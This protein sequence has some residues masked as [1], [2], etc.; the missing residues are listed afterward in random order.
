[1]AVGDS[2]AEI[3]PCESRLNPDGS[4]HDESL[5]GGRAS[6][7]PEAML[8]G[9]QIGMSPDAAKLSVPV[10]SSKESELDNRR[11]RKIDEAL[12]YGLPVNWNSCE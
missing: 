5:T 12:N 7:E 10:N 8:L 2:N 3:E 9:N 6:N 11:T 1:M 4:R